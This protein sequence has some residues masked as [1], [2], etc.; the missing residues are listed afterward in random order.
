MA[1][2]DLIFQRGFPTEVKAEGLWIKQGCAKPLR[3]D[4]AR[5]IYMGIVFQSG[6]L[7]F[8]P[9]AGLRL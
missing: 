3:D 5:Q 1:R 7:G 2:F 4:L 6:M 9:F 8:F